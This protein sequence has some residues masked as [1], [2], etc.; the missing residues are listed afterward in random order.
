MNNCYNDELFKSNSA[1]LS[2]NVILLSCSARLS[3]TKVFK[4]N[5][6]LG[7]IQKLPVSFKV[8]WPHNKK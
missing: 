6:K 3:Y 2:T 1:T 8:A 5:D 7:K 4:L